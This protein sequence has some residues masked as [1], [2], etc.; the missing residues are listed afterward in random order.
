MVGATGFRG[1]QWAGGCQWC[2]T[3]EFPLP[4]ELWAMYVE[5]C[6]NTT[7]HV[8]ESRR[9]KSAICRREG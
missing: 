1:G 7:P 5:I 6:I 4:V 8:P 2:T 9:W 3:D